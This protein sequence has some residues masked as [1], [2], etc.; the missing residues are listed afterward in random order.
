MRSVIAL[1]CQVKPVFSLGVEV[2]ILM[3]AGCRAFMVGWIVRHLL[4]QEF[5]RCRHVMSFPRDCGL[6]GSSWAR[7][8]TF[9]CAPCT[10]EI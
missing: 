2:I 4:G 9:H 6:W 1:P 5:C 3:L 10:P 7:V 8:T